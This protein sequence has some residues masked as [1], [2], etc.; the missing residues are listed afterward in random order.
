MATSNKI[1]Y[2]FV[3]IDEFTKTANKI[4]KTINNLSN[5]TRKTSKS[6]KE[7]LNDPLGKVKETT[8]KTNKELKSLVENFNKAPAPIKRS[9]S[10][11]SRFTSGIG[12]A[13]KHLSGFTH[14]FTQWAD[15]F[16]MEAYFKFM[17]IALPMGIVA[18]LGLEYSNSLHSANISMES[19]FSKTKNFAVYQ[20]AITEQAKKF[21]VHT[22]FSRAEYLS[23]TQAVALKTGSMKIAAEFMPT[24]IGYA[25]IMGKYK[26]GTLAQ[27]AQELITDVMRGQ[28][29]KLPITTAQQEELHHIL[30]G[31]ASARLDRYMKWYARNQKK[32]LEAEKR[33]YHTSAVQVA[34][35]GNQFG[36]LSQ[37]IV[38]TIEP[39]FEQL[40]RATISTVASMI[41]FIKNHKTFANVIGKAALLVTGL[42]GGLI[43]LGAVV[44]GASLAMAVLNP[45]TLGAAAALSLFGVFIYGLIKNAPKTY[46]LI[47]KYAHEPKKFA[48]DIGAVIHHPGAMLDYYTGQTGKESVSIM[49]NILIH[50]STPHPVTHEVGQHS[51]SNGVNYNHHTILTGRNTGSFNH[52]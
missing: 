46:R 17:N 12:N 36:H 16:G 20:K 9:T 50:N 38:D 1:V 23:A 7:G 41:D 31:P 42:L 39:T 8:K 45:A 5:A 2:T 33:L 44:G 21:G 3:A 48:H 51:S 14:T 37:V 19:L 52:E 13:A 24:A 34:I 30:A 32:F 10:F 40:R 25:A 4:S 49:H 28:I 6:L 26:K 15:K 29:G 35:V 27:T 47:K 11:I 18:H 22:P 43:T